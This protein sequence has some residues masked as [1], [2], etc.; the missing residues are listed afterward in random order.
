MVYNY[1]LDLYR[2][3]EIRKKEISAHLPRTTDSEQ[4][5]DYAQGRLDA[6]TEFESYLRETFHSKLPRRM[7]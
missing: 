1:L 5:L 7:Q 2:I 6:V 4:P 3:L